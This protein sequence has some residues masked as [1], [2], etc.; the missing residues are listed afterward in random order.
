MFLEKSADEQWQT[1]FLLVITAW[2]FKNAL[3]NISRCIKLGNLF[4]I[5]Y[6]SHVMFEAWHHGD[7]QWQFT[8]VSKKN[9]CTVK[10][11]IQK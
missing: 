4:I 5:L 8:H 6:I 11:V 1:L 9:V 3:L 10:L 7:Y 2:S